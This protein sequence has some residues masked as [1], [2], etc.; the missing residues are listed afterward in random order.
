MEIG[1]NVENKSI[2]SVQSVPTFSEQFPEGARDEKDGRKSRQSRRVSFATSTQLAQYLEPINPFDSL[3]ERQSETQLELSSASL[4]EE[5]ER[6]KNFFL[7]ICRTFPLCKQKRFS[8]RFF[9]LIQSQFQ[10]PTPKSSQ[11]STVSRAKSTIPVRYHR[12]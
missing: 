6:R 2:H 7:T 5:N 3:G 11:I 8:S 1:E 12:S 9:P 10:S 4:M